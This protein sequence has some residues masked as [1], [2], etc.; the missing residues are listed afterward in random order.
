M[1]CV[2]PLPLGLGRAFVL[3]RLT[4]E[5]SG[6]PQVL[7]NQRVEPLLTAGSAANDAASP[8]LLLKFPPGRAHLPLS[9]IKVGWGKTG[10]TSS[11]SAHIKVGGGG[12]PG[13][14]SVG[15]HQV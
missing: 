11:R 3:K 8:R 2:P 10:M 4:A 1:I 13:V 6:P 15:E 14:G 5:V 9:D 7:L 12:Q